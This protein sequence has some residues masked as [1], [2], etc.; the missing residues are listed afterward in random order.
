[1]LPITYRWRKES[2]SAGRNIIERIL[3]NRGVCKKEEI[4]SFL[5]PNRQELHSPYLL[6]DMDKAVARIVEMQEQK[7]HLVIYGDYDVD[8]ITSTSVLYMFLKSM[9]YDVSYYIP[10]RQTEGYGLNKEAIAK[11]NEYADLIITVDTGIAAVEELA[12][13]NSLGLDIII[14]D[15]HECQEVLPEAYCIINPKRKDCKYPFDAL[16][17]V[18]VTFKLIHALAL[19]YQKEERIWQYIDLVALG[20]IADVVPLIGENRVIA[21]MGFEVMKST[22]HIG[23]RE[24]LNLVGEG[25]IKEK[26]TSNMIAYQVGPRLNAAGRLGDAK[27]G[28]ELLTTQDEAKAK[29]LAALLDEENKRRQDMESEI[30]REAEAYIEKHIDSEKEKVFVVVGSEWHHGV[31]GIVASRIMAKYYRPTIVLTEEDGVLSGSARSIEGFNIFEAVNLTKEHLLRFGGHEMAAGLSL[32]KDNLEVFKKTINSYADEII[33]EEMLIPS[34]AIDLELN[35]RNLDLDFCAQLERLEPFGACN[36]VP[37]FSIKGRVLSVMKMGQEDKHLRL[38][39][40]QEGISLTAVG[41]Y[42]GYLAD[43]LSIGEEVIAGGEIIKNRWNNKTTLQLRIKDLQSPEEEVLRSKYYTSLFHYLKDPKPIQTIPQLIAD[44]EKKEESKSVCVYT[45]ESLYE[46]CK[47]AKN[48]S[49]KIN[50][51]L[52]VCYNKACLKRE[53]EPMFIVNPIEPLA[54]KYNYEWDF[55]TAD[56]VCSVYQT[57]LNR[58]KNQLVKMIPGHKDCIEVYK[59]LKNDAHEYIYV[60]KAI[61][62]LSAY[63]MTEYKLFQILEV[64]EELNILK[65][66]V[67]QDCIYYEL[68]A[69]DK[70]R[71]ERSSK[72]RQLHQFYDAVMQI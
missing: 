9:D 35:L 42:K 22:S 25:E 49:K 68:V 52:K 54:E 13:A 50:F 18:G 56:H 60:H 44:K 37:L 34:M 55:K 58:H 70:T 71:L 28:V 4:Q 6:N 26:I 20:T 39:L 3:S 51:N 41:F 5:N 24:L 19:Y 62:Y 57:T 38:V 69:A 65:Y 47:W 63:K 29:R 8:G 48:K 32:Q 2:D 40:E 11:I 23:L 7:K 14:T 53:E 67:L 27:V 10:N 33:D 61:V 30:V 15:H 46:V 36:P 21:F 45:E 16:A 72:Y 17:G 66:Q 43:Y 1:M 31:I 12:F 59:L 64:F